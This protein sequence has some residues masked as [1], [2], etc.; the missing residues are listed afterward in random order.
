M[1][2]FWNLYY[3]IYLF[4]LREERDNKLLEQNNNCA[5]MMEHDSVLASGTCDIAVGLKESC[6][7]VKQARSSSNILTRFLSIYSLGLI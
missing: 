1:C 3:Y 7:L 5:V 4:S 2:Y 6:C